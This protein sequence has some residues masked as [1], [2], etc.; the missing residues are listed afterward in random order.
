MSQII[1]KIFQ[2]WWFMAMGFLRQNMKTY[3][4]RSI[5]AIKSNICKTRAIFKFVFTKQ[6]V[7][8]KGPWKYRYMSLEVTNTKYSIVV[9]DIP[10]T[11]IS[12]NVCLWLSGPYFWFQIRDKWRNK[13]TMMP[14]GKI[15]ILFYTQVLSIFWITF[16]TTNTCNS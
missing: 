14:A 6:K 7:W 3:F 4:V 8:D 10:D 5:T 13:Q 16:L 2:Y 11:N 15:I 9:H 1:K 12:I